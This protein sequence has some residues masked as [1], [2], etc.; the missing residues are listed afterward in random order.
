MSHAPYLS[1]SGTSPPVAQQFDTESTAEEAMK[2]VIGSRESANASSIAKRPRAASVRESKSESH[3]LPWRWRRQRQRQ[4]K[5]KWQSV[6]MTDVSVVVHN[7]HQ[8]YSDGIT[9]GGWVDPGGIEE[10]QTL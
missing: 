6:L 5:W 10:A 9:G 4:W 7:D 8:T 1:R 2:A 3:L